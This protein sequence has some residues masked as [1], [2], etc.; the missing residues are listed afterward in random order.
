MMKQNNKIRWFEIGAVI[1]TG[2]F[3]FLFVNVFN[4]QPVFIG[5]SIL[6]WGLYIGYRT[7]RNKNILKYWGF[8]KTHFYPAFK[9]AGLFALICISIFAINAL[10]N[11]YQLFNMHLFFV[12][13]LY[14]VWGLIQQFMMMSLILGNLIDWSSNKNHEIIYILIT[15]VMFSAVHF[16]SLILMI[17]TFI[18]AIYYSLIFLKYRNLYPLGLFHG[19]IG[20][21]FYYYVLHYDSWKEIIV[22][23]FNF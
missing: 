17:L 21:F 11:H 23:L 3:K 5:A 2:I 15:S 12:L 6:F 4:L 1:I 22:P 8:T 19:W 16:P 14:P 7:S 18:L 13:L 20:G 10:Y 9:M